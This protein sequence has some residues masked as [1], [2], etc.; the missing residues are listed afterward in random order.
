MNRKILIEDSRKELLS[1]IN[2]MANAVKSTM[3]PQ[4]RNVLIQDEYGK[5]RST[6]DGVTVAKNIYLKDPIENIAAEVLREVASKTND[7]VG[8]GTTTATMLAQILINKGFK[9]I[10]KGY[11]PNTLKNEMEVA[12]EKACDFIEKSSV[13][14]SLSDSALLQHVAT[15][16]ANNDVKLGKLLAEAFVA[17]GEDGVVNVRE[18]KKIEDSFDLVPGMRFQRGYVSTSFINNHTKKTYEGQ[19]VLVLIIG[20]KVSGVDDV[21]DLI[22]RS[23]KYFAEKEDFRANCP[24]LIVCDD[25]DDK[26]VS[27]FAINALKGLLNNCVIKS[28]GI[29][30]D[31]E[32]LIKDF[33]MFT[34]ATILGNRYGKPINTAGPNDFGYVK[35]VTVSKDEITISEGQSNDEEMKKYISDL[36]YQ[37]EHHVEEFGK[38]KLNQRIARLLGGVGTIY[39]GGHTELEI[40]EKMD[41]IDDALRSMEASIEDGII[42]GGGSEFLRV[43][44]KMDNGYYADSFVE[45]KS[46]GEKIVIEAI[47]TPFT[48]LLYNYNVN[49]VTSYNKIVAEISSHGDKAG[50]NMVT[51]E[52]VSDMIEAGIIDSVKVAKSSLRNAVSVAGIFLTTSFV[53]GDIGDHSED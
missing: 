50:M 9:E 1:G 26:A 44:N 29:N 24:M 28:P 22:E 38:N 45:S 8:D 2:K 13:K 36:K 11:D 21:L 12:A 32:D 18:G 37:S 39:A 23:K 43:A 35:K 46:M 33:A 49:K 10:E 40:K 31:R 41:R 17:V 3:G 7:I 4:G 42:P 48:Q 47:K 30:L 14:I 6:K 15:V 20:Q 27:I 51:G 34:G 53:I 19:D 16:S 25:I 5:V 52:V